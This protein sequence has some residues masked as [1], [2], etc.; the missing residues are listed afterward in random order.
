VDHW[1]VVPEL[2]GQPLPLEEL[3]KVLPVVNLLIELEA[4]VE[5]VHLDVFRVVSIRHVRPGAYL[6][7]ISAKSHPLER[8]RFGLLTL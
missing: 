2:N 6:W 5:L 1:V 4:V 3:L 8:S 7:R